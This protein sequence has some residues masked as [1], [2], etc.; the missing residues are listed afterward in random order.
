[1]YETLLVHVLLCGSETMVWKEKEKP[2]IR[3]VQMDNLR[4]LLG[5]RR[6]YRE[7]NS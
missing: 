6:M 4:D 2:M 1:M 5:I 7:P 3:V